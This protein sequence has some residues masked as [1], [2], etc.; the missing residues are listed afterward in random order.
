VGKDQ[1]LATTDEAKLQLE[2]MDEIAQQ[3]KPNQIWKWVHLR[4]PKNVLRD[5]TRQCLNVKDGAKGAGSK[6]S[7]W[8]GK[9]YDACTFMF[10]KVDED[11]FLLF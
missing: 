8:P 2:K 11:K 4:K 7:A 3:T 9:T 6:M 5:G 10:V 1:G